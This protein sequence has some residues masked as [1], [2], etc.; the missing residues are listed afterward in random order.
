M[1]SLHSPQN[2]HFDGI[3]TEN[4]LNMICHLKILT[5]AVISLRDE[6]VLLGYSVNEHE[7]HHK[8]VTGRIGIRYLGNFLSLFSFAGK[9]LIKT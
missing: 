1:Y 5:L 3:Y 9:A 6:G 7:A 8:P 2:E 4:V